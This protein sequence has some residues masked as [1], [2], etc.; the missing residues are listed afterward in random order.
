MKKKAKIIIG[1][2]TTVSLVLILVIGGVV[3]LFVYVWS[4][5]NSR[6]EL[7][8]KYRAIADGT[9]FGKTTDKNGCVSKDFMLQVKD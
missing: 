2:M 9:A 6:N 8:D 5:G 4:R 3:G 1:V 7:K